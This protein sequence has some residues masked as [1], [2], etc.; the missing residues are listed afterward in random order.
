MRE[1]ERKMRETKQQILRE[2]I[3]TA[4]KEII[5]LTNKM[6]EMLPP[7]GEGERIEGV[8]RN[9]RRRCEDGQFVD[10]WEIVEKIKEPV[11]SLSLIVWKRSRIAKSG[12]EHKF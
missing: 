6:S 5:E 4:E 2:K 1:N 8:E 10:F 11:G 7:S 9:R 12:K 3:R